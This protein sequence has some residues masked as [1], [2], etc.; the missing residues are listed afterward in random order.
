MSF[1]W[2]KFL[3]V[4]NHLENYSQEESYQRSAVGRYY[5]SCY[6]SAKDYF[7]KEHFPLGH[8][9]SPHQTLIDCLRLGYNKNEVDLAEA[10]S[11]LRRYRNKADYYQGFRSNILKKAKKTTEDIYILLSDLEN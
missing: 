11:K 2:K 1:N 9:N 5:Y 4:G 3:E 8:R 6:H 10:L 7:E